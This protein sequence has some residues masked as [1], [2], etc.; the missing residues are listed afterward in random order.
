MRAILSP[1]KIRGGE[2]GGAARNSRI[3]FYN[4][5]MS[6]KTVSAAELRQKQL[7][8]DQ[9]RLIDV[10][11]LIEYEM[12][13]IESAELLPLSD[14]AA[15]RDKL[16]RDE[17]IVVMCHHGVRSAHVCRYLSEQGFENVANLDG[18]IDAWS[19]EVD[20]RVPRY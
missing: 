17:E 11:E 12:A 2:T 4:S 13:R 6:F 3:L 15:W 8:G 10:R 7:R 16:H 20:W 1:I 14:F 18:G 9:F 19:T 5:A